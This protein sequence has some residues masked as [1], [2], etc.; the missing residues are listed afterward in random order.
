M[1]DVLR[2]GLPEPIPPKILK[3]P[4][5][6]G[7][8]VPYFTAWLD[9]ERATP[10]GQGVPDF[11]VTFPNA[12]AQCYKE[13]LCWVCGGSLYAWKA[14]V[15]GPMCAVNR[16]S[17]EPPSHVDCADWAAKACPFLA[18]PHAKR[19]DTSDVPGRAEKMPGVAI[20]RNPGAAGV[21]VVKKYSLK[22][23]PRGGVL[24]NMGEPS[25]VRWY[26]EGRE[27]TRAEIQRS[28][29]TGLP[30]LQEACQGR[31]RDLAELERYVERAQP[32]LPA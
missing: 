32:L 9:G 1:S 18:R 7:Y 16:T 24:F 17:A 8:P 10:R 26:A 3:L 23:D 5:H 11:R 25:E 19:R 14:F 27:A 28:I 31:A 21:W 2:S 6:R 30:Y 22:R 29:D 15:I 20:M 4:V 13:K 12:I